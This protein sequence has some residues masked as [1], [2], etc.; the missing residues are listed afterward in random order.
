[1]SEPLLEIRGPRSRGDP[2][3]VWSTA[4]ILITITGT[5][6]LIIWLKGGL[7]DPFTPRELIPTTTTR[8][9]IWTVLAGPSLVLLVVVMDRIRARRRSVA[10]FEHEVVFVEHGF[11]D[12]AIAWDRLAGYRDGNASF[13]RL[14]E[15]DR[16]LLQGPSHLLVPTRTEAERTAVLALLDRKGLRRIEG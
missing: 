1:L 14:V 2:L 11:R 13:V 3:Q 9:L 12:V 5:I 8:A 16:R 10:F 6:L 15:K 7:N 4:A